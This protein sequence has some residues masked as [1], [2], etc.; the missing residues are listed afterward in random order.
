MGGVYELPEYREEDYPREEIA[1]LR[2]IRVRKK[3]SVALVTDANT[4]IRIGDK[5]EM[6]KGF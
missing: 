1:V 2:V 4:D 3:T 5:V 6:K